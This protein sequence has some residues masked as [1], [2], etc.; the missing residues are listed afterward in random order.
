[1][2]GRIVNCRKIYEQLPNAINERLAYRVNRFQDASTDSQ[3]LLVHL[4][5]KVKEDPSILISSDD[6]VRQ[7]LALR[8]SQQSPGRTPTSLEVDPWDLGGFSQM[9]L[10][11]VTMNVGAEPWALKAVR[12]G[13]FQQVKDMIAKD[14]KA[15][16]SV[17]GTG[18]NGLHYAA[19][20][21]QSEFIS[22]FLE[23]PDALSVNDAGGNTHRYTTLHT[24]SRE[25]N[26]DCVRELLRY[27]ADVNA[28]SM[29][30]GDFSL[31]PL[32]LCILTLRKHTSPQK[33]LD[34]VSLLLGAGSSTTF[35][36]RG[37][38]I[39]HLLAQSNKDEEMLKI[40]VQHH[41]QLASQM[42]PAKQ[43]P[44]HSAA[45]MRNLAAVKVLLSFGVSLYARN[46]TGDTP[47]YNV[48]MSIG[49]ST[50]PNSEHYQEDYVEKL[51]GSVEDAKE[52]IRLLIEAV[53][54][55]VLWEYLTC[56]GTR[57]NSVCTT[58]TRMYQLLES[59][60]PP[61]S[62]K[63]PTPVQNYGY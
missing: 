56:H 39:T 7:L 47:L 37:L 44:L 34:T 2:C 35:R 22:I 12:E 53:R 19:Y 13:K 50:R 41:P 10:R 11:E 28:R 63:L 51:V 18:W 31:T 62:L 27:G 14:S 55:R 23:E 25:A 21:G 9:Y 49:P 54:T 1:M 8:L 61:S 45:G 38:G 26:V 24:A 60:Q 57:Q 36:Y 33:A 30:T 52:V 3:T 20:F 43:A 58:S 15:R 59:P 6:L 46:I 29:T 40:V 16:R 48:Y 42:T 32:Q 4:A 17:I 5:L